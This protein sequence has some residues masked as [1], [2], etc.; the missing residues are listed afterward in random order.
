[1]HRGIEK[2]RLYLERLANNRAFTVAPNKIR[3]LQ[4]RFDEATLR[5][6]QDMRQLV[7]NLHHQDQMLSTRLKKVDLN[8]FIRHK[9]EILE[10]RYQGLT[11]G[12]R[13]F[14]QGDQARFAL[15]VGKMDSLSPLAILKRGFSVCRD[16]QGAVIKRSTE[17]AG[18]DHVQVTL[19]SGELE[20]IIE[21]IRHSE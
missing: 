16:K 3:D 1:M 2:R 6:S 20:C 15:A 8:R 11:S 13:A 7:S 17:V 18:G 10:S 5:L 14:L 12:I 4:Q 19:A 9:R 21:K